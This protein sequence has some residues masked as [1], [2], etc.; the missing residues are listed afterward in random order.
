MNDYNFS[1]DGVGNVKKSGAT[2]PTPSGEAGSN[3]GGTGNVPAVQ[4]QGSPVIVKTGA[5]NGQVDQ[6]FA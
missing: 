3:Y 4:G 2:Q 5:T 6:P 1:L